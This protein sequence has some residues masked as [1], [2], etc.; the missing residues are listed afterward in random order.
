MAW[1]PCYART[2]SGPAQ[3]N[4]KSFDDSR[5]VSAI[6]HVTEEFP[7]PQLPRSM[8]VDGIVAIIIAASLIRV[9][10]IME[11]LHEG[12]RLDLGG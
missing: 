10:V 12:L 6:Y 4:G 1:F 9:K 3:R 11:F 7:I 5:L 8:V 2:N